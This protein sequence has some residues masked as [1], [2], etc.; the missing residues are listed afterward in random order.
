MGRER[1]AVRDSGLVPEPRDPATDAGFRAALEMMPDAVVIVDRSGEITF[2]N[3]RAHEVFGYVRAELV[4]R[5]VEVLLPH[6]LRA[7]HEMHRRG[8]A[9]APHARAMGTGGTLS[10]RRKDGGEVPVEVMVTP[11]GDGSGA[12]TAVIRDVTDR[13][14]AQEALATREETFRAMFSQNPHA[15]WVFDRETLRFL[16]VNDAAVAQYGYSREEFLAM[17]IADIRPKTHLP[18]LVEFLHGE[19][20]PYHLAGEWLHRRKDG[21]LLSVEISVHALTYEGREAGLVAAY[22]VT[23][24]AR[25]ERRLAE[26]VRIERLATERLRALNEMK[27]AFLSAVSHE[28]RTPLASVLGFAHTIADNGHR[29]SDAEKGDLLGRIVHG[30]ERLDRLITDLVDLDRIRHAAAAA[31]REPVDLSSLVR[32]TAGTADLEDRPLLLHVEEVGEAA[33]DRAQVERI[34]DNLLSNAVRYTPPGTPVTVH[35]ARHGDAVLLVVEDRG[36]GVPDEFKR[37]IFEMFRQGPG[38]PRHAPGI[39]VG[40]SLVARFA[41]LHGGQAW[42]EDRPGG[43][44]SFKVLLRARRPSEASG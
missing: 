5:R 34:L 27:D 14:R 31:A 17:T 39:G 23:A 25:A 18:A 1:T 10:G 8:F 16:E 30:A 37:Q 33:A 6:R 12:V 19:R 32:R 40:L 20:P 3:P 13:H 43:G 44:A 26:A 22:D 2:A 4:G 36:P 42:V 15:M 24:R 21:S 41:E 9:T 7:S 28:L 29:L 38:T 35:L 11:L